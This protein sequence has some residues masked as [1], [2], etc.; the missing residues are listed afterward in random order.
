MSFLYPA[1]LIGALAVA[2]PIVLHFLRRDVAPTVPFSAVRLLRSS[3]IARSRRRRLRDM[4]LLAA[5]IAALLLLATAFARP[6]LA[7]AARGPGLRIIAIDRSFSMN[8]PGRFAHAI[9]LARRAIDEAPTGERVAL[10]AF[11]DHAQTIAPP[12]PAAAARAS[13]A[14]LAPTFAGTRF[15]EVFSKAIEIAAGEAARLVLVS[16]LQR[17]GWE[18]EERSMLPDGVVV[19]VRDAG[20]PPPNLAI[21]SLLALPDRVVA[22]I[23]NTANEPRSGQIRIDHDGRPAASATYKVPAGSTTDIAIPFRAPATGSIAAVIDDP[24]GLPADN[25]RFAVLDPVPPQSVLLITSAG[26]SGYYVT[27]ALAAVGG[28]H[29][30]QIVPRTMSAPSVGRENLAQASSIVLLSTHGL[31]QRSRESLAGFV[32]GGGGL[33]IAASPEVE[34]AVVSAIFGW[35]SVMTGSVE[36]AGSAALSPIDLRHPIFR[37]FGALAANLGQIRFTTAWRL[38]IDGWDVI[39]R[40]TDGNPAVV[41]RREGQGRVVLFASDLDRQWNDFPLNPAFVPFTVEAV[42]Y[43]SDTRERR[44]DF[45]VGAAPAPAGAAPG[46]YQVGSDNHAI[47]VNVDPRESATATLSGQD[48]AAMIEHVSGNQSLSVEVAAVHLEARQSY[49]QYGLML[50]LAALVAE[51]FVGRG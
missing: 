19:D 23:R 46:I 37:P 51:S 38:T 27:R 31:G 28:S 14:T 36:I 22:G 9:D 50:M 11:D 43:I 26:D 8:A 10:V 48:F 17:A 5:R 20:A 4:L 7:N 34:S 24:A 30:D 3:P 6:Y 49:W 32:R 12:G 33:L 35:P 44:R 40:F 45:V 47:A 16:D 2:V 39:A 21:V 25:S 13:L 1:F 29:G 42:R 18:G 41:E 15:G